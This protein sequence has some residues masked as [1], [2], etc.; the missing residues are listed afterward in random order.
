MNHAYLQHFCFQAVIRNGL[1]FVLLTELHTINAEV[2]REF[3][4]PLSREARALICGY[5]WK[6]VLDQLRF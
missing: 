3:K 4:L 2:S 5:L 1:L 6:H